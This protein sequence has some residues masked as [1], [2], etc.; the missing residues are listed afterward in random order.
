M[1]KK[2]LASERVDRKGVKFINKGRKEEDANEK[3]NHDRIMATGVE[4]MP[5][6]QRMTEQVVFANRSPSFWKERGDSI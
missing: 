4:F 5:E 1:R 6:F 3:T 2:Y